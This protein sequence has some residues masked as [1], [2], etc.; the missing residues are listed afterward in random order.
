MSNVNEPHGFKTSLP[1]AISTVAKPITHADF[2][3]SAAELAQADAAIIT[4]TQDFLFT[5]DG[6]TAPVIATSLGHPVSAGTL[7]AVQGGRRVQQLNFIRKT[8]DGIM[9]ITLEKF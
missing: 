5:E 1:C 7:L 3:F 4:C 8:A 9:T 6:S 2:G